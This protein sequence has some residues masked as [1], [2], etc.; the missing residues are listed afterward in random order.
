VI[1]RSLPLI[2][3]C[4]VAAAPAAG[5][6]ADADVPLTSAYLSGA[7]SETSSNAYD[8]WWDS[9]HDP[10]LSR[11]V[12]RA[13]AQNLDLQQARA[14]VLQSRAAARAAGAAL[15]PQARLNASATDERLSLRS[16]IGEIGS[17]LPGF[18]RAYDDYAVGAAAS[19][20]IDLFGGLRKAR[21]AARAD[22]QAA[23]RDADA[24][25][26]SVAAEAADAYLQVRAFQGR[27][28]VA[29]R[30][31][32]VQQDLVEL[33][34]RRVAEGVSPDRELRQAR[35]A[36][37]GVTASIPPLT[38]GRDLQLNR[39]DLLMGAQAGTYRGELATPAP[40]PALPA[41]GADVPADLLRRRP[42]ILA[43]EQRLVAADARIGAAVADYYPRISLSALFGFESLAAGKLFIGAA[44]QHAV[45]AGLG[46][47]LFDFGRVDAAVAQARGAKA[48]ALSAYRAAVYHATA[49]VEDA[50]TQLG[51]QQLRAEALSRQIDQLT[52][53]R[54]QVQQAYEGGVADLIEVRDADRE[55][56]AASDQLVQARSAAAR[57]AVNGFRAL[58]GGWATEPAPASDRLV[59]RPSARLGPAS[60]LKEHSNG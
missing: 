57:A 27:L 29:Q 20:E 60:S 34:S 15:L 11:V 35:A 37:D 39:L 53:A 18:A 38:A 17:Q 55:L 51:E 44:N 16:P 1:R 14:R 25:R 48:E 13:V 22:A 42:D 45:G 56:L 23:A 12:R 40:L 58:G 41:L 33:L 28:A 30:Q 10:G 43:A 9:F 36:L 5:R 47:R 2:L 52:A 59:P 46:W 7:V 4:A 49:E 32:Q 50:F 6:A 19:W 3:A 31:L 8:A 54:R 21:A 24:V 26:L